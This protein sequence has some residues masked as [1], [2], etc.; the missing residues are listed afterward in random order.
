MTWIFWCLS[1]LRC[2]RCLCAPFSF[3]SSYHF[4]FTTFILITFMELNKPNYQSDATS[5][6]LVLACLYM[7]ICIRQHDVNILCTPNLEV[8]EMIVCSVFFLLV[9][10]LAIH[11][12]VFKKLLHAYL[13]IGDLRILLRYFC[14]RQHD[15][16]ILY[17]LILRCERCLCAPFFSIFSF[18]RYLP[19]KTTKNLFQSSNFVCSLDFFFLFL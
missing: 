15:V 17:T 14:I 1:F 10:L 11:S 5:L 16:N 3:S 6:Y 8:W 13:L 19:V 4:Q 2:E 9:T 12:I 7:I 18:L